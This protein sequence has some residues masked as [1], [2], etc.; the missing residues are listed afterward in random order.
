MTPP[1]IKEARRELGL[2][3]KALGEKLGRSERAVRSWETNPKNPS[4]RAIDSM[5]VNLI[6]ALLT[7][8]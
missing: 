4:Y 6:K 5:A 2:T 7:E 1:E 8:N 3:Q